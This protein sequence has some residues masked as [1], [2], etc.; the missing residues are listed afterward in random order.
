MGSAAQGVESAYIYVVFDGLQNTEIL[1]G[2]VRERRWERRWSVGWVAAQR[3]PSEFCTFH[4][5]SAN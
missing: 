2:E 5:D 1:S 4:F 3:F